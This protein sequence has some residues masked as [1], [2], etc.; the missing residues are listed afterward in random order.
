MG[1]A[2]VPL[3]LALLNTFGMGVCAGFAV[4]AAIQGWGAVVAVNSIGVAINA[5]LAAVNLRG[6]QRAM[7][8]R[9]REAAP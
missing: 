1:R 8:E 5:G 9:D 7:I 6:V 3:V 2:K 4:A